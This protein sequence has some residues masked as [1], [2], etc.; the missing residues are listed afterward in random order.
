MT[1]QCVTVRIW[2]KRA[3]T[4]GFWS[5]HNI[6]SGVKAD[7][8]MENWLI[9]P[10]GNYFGL[11][12]K[13]TC[14]YAARM[15]ACTLPGIN[16]PAVYT[17]WRLDTCRHCTNPCPVFPVVMN[18]TS[19]GSIWPRTLHLPIDYLNFEGCALRRRLG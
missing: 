4:Q 1:K 10:V 18:W 15:F 12:G 3:E 11:T 6:W 13:L 17:T 8:T 16:I 5:S 2:R 19:R 7:L 9:R 14:L